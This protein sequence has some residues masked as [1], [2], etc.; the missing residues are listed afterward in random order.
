MEEREKEK[1]NTSRRHFTAFTTSFS[2]LLTAASASDDS[3]SPNQQQ[4]YRHNSRSNLDRRV[5][6]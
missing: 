2:D 6:V 5:K 1:G 3:L 4:N